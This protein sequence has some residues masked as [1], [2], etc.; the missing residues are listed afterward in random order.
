MEAP[1]R[2]FPSTWLNI[3]TQPEFLCHLTKGA[4]L[5]MQKIWKEMNPTGKGQ[6]SLEG[7]RNGNEFS[8]KEL[9]FAGENTSC[10]VS[11]HLEAEQVRRTEQYY[12]VA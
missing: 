9:I 5:I 2:K 12:S 7:R 4:L 11:S 1:E 10:Y 3:G 6:R 8:I